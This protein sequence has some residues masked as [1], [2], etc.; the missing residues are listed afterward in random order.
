MSIQFEKTNSASG[1]T[2]PAAA[3]KLSGFAPGEDAQYHTLNDAVVVLK[4]RM[5]AAEVI[6]AAWSLQKLSAELCAHVAA[7]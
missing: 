7:L 2:V 1:I 4:K 5:N 3:M 6:R